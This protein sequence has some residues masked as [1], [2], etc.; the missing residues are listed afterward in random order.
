MIHL[1][2]QYFIKLPSSKSKIVESRTSNNSE[3]NQPWGSNASD[4][5]STYL[6]DFRVLSD[7]E[8]TDCKDYGLW[9][10]SDGK[11]YDFLGLLCGRVK[12]R[13]TLP[14]TQS[15]RLNSRKALS[16]A[17]GPLRTNEDS[18]SKDEV[19]EFVIKFLKMIQV[20]LNATVQN[21]KTDNGTKFVNQTLREAITTACFTQNRSLILKRH[22]KTPYEL[23]YN[24]KP[25]LSYLYVFG[26]L[27]Y[28]TNDSE[29]L[30]KLQTKADIGI[31]VGY[32]LTKKVFRIYNTW[33]RLITKTIHVDFDELTGMASEQFS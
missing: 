23:L 4:V 25:N 33:T 19:T 11:C 8:T 10:L 13:N 15:R 9:R 5:P 1:R 7:L 18:K 28:P 30:S 21:I 32:A 20:R 12:A 29:D 16:V 31:F 27:C 3:P 17:H 22:N 24:K 6:V 26:A 14:Q 2:T